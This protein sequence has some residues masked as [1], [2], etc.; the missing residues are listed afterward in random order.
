MFNPTDHDWRSYYRKEA[1]RYNALRYET[2]YGQLFKELHYK[3]LE[4]F[5]RSCLPGRALDVAAG[6]GHV[7]MLLASMGI[8]LTAIDMTEAMLLQARNSL[9]KKRLKAHFLLGNAF[10]LPFGNEVFKIVISTRFLHLWPYYR[11]QDLL[12]EMARVLQRKGILILDFY[13]RLHQEIF[14]IPILIY[15]KMLKKKQIGDE[16]YNR[17]KQ[18]LAMIESEGFSIL[19]VK[20]VGGYYLIIPA[21]VLKNLVSVVD[22]F[23]SHFPLLHLSEQFLVKGQKN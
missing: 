3:G 14:Q 19:D 4:K 2:H 11:Q 8:D 9:K 16:N 20:G 7:S 5:L 18:S 12:H 15:R 17:I 6:T 10:E 13:N 23:S 1:K 21:L 22:R